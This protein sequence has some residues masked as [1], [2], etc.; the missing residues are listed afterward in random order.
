MSQ[1]SKP[2][3]RLVSERSPTVDDYRKIQILNLDK[4]D[5]DSWKE[6]L[7]EFVQGLDRKLSPL[8]PM[9]AQ[10]RDMQKV[11]LDLSDRVEEANTSAEESKKESAQ[12]RK[13]L[14]NLQTAFTQMQGEKAQLQLKY[15]RLYE[16]QISMECYSRRSNLN[17]DNVPEDRNEQPQD[18]LSKFYNV[19][20]RHMGIKN[21][22]N[23]IKI[24][25]CHRVGPK[26]DN[27]TRPIIAKF[28][29]YVDRDE[30]WKRR[31]SLRG[32]QMWMREDFPAEVE[33]RR[34][35]LY[36][37]LQ[38][39][40][41]DDR[42]KARARMHIDKLSINGGLYSVDQLD[43]LPDGLKPE[44]IATKC[45]ENVTLFYHKESPFSNFHPAEF[46]VDGVKYTC[47]EQFSQSQKAILFDDDESER[48]IMAATSPHQMYTLGR[49]VKNFNEQ[50]WYGGRAKELM[51]KG[52]MAK[53]EQNE[54]LKKALLATGTTTLA[55][56]SKN[57]FWGIGMSV[58]DPR[59]SDTSSWT[60]ANNLGKCLE[61][62]RSKL[63]QSQPQSS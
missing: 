62:V 58:T 34:R 17:I 3:A 29:W 18:T 41:R 30:V 16:K 33:S 46:V 63:R 48:K 10:I 53:Y 55:E 32:T 4:E 57:T 61:I 38:A 13:D 2:R 21:A 54:H 19:L 56:G 14:N 20:E 49:K 23:F 25:R 45:T 44:Q 39:A 6:W 60:G 15:D 7:T 27:H 52:N 1:D 9:A 5:F 28:N 42:Y 11:I 22:K 36:P 26:R 35:K 43:Q 47:T 8:E 50:K 31:A 12:T 24:E 40:R 59:A 37:V 51:I